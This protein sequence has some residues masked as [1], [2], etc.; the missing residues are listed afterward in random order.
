MK[1]AKSFFNKYFM[2]R[3]VK[4]GVLAVFAAAGSAGA[5]TSWVTGDNTISQSATSQSRTGWS[6]VEPAPGQIAL[7]S[8]PLTEVLPK[9][10]TVETVFRAVLNLHAISLDSPGSFEVLRV[11][12]SFSE[13]QNPTYL[14]RPAIAST[15]TGVVFSLDKGVPRPYYVD[16]TAIVKEAIAAGQTNLALAIQ[17]SAAS[18]SAKAT[19]WARES[20]TISTWTPALKP[21]V[22][23][24]ISQVMPPT[25]FWATSIGQSSCL[26]VCAL[27]NAVAVPDATGNICRGAGLI[28]NAE[29]IRSPYPVG[30][31]GPYFCST[32]NT[33]ACH[34]RSK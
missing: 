12:S 28:S 3:L 32:N 2:S 17:P 4:T 26:A 25:L 6:F 29:T 10:A 23:I 14:T 11:T 5:V 30:A 27:A 16:I 34:C 13:A 31:S 9:N 15:G 1:I 22:E 24:E 21:N 8:F 19:F 18:P 7:M 33:S 20:A